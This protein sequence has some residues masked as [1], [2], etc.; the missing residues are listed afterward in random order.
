MAYFAELDNNNIVIR[1]ISI[2]DDYCKDANGNEVESIGA[3]Y[4]SSLFGGNWKQ[5]SF[6]TFAGHHPSKPPF[7][8]NY[9]GI[10]YFYDS[11]LDAFIPPKSYPSWVL[12]ENTGQW[13]SPIPYPSDNKSYIW[14][15]ETVSWVFDE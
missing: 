15:E 2:N 10:G 4:C 1:V 6:N 7:R 11:Q 9:A 5:T 13:E 8:K 12:N 14:N 3:N